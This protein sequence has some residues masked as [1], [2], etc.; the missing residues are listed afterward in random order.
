MHSRVGIRGLEFET[1]DWRRRVLEVGNVSTPTLLKVDRFVKRCK[2]TGLWQQL[3]RVNLCVGMDLTSS[4]VPLKNDVGSATETNS[5]LVSTDYSES[6]GWQTNGTTKRL[7]TG[8]APSE[9]TGGICVYLRST[10]TSDTN[11]RTAI[12]GRVSTTQRHGLIANRDG[13]GGTSAGAVRGQWG[14]STTATDPFTTGGMIAGCWHIIRRS[15]TDAELYFNGASVATANPA[16]APGTGQ[17]AYVLCGNEAGSAATFLEANSKIAGYSF[18]NGLVTADAA[19]YYRI[20]Q[21]FQRA[22][23]RQV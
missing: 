17:E 1:Q 7:Q 10:Q 12:G 13:T 11:G 22:I 20:W 6:T 14:G 8:Y 21:D 19:I 16:I 23:G 18:D 4:L 9:A 15:T 2:G 5:N 3:R